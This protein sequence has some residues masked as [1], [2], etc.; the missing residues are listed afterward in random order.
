[1]DLVDGLYLR[2]EFA[3][4]NERLSEI[5]RKIDALAEA[6][7]SVGPVPAVH[8][9]VR[10]LLRAGFKLQ[11]V[12]AYQQTAG[13]DLAAAEA[14]IDRWGGPIARADAENQS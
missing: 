5:E 3:R 6:I 8:P 13:V 10:E 1:M 4:L 12:K 11:A 2:R 7:G 14:F 9:S